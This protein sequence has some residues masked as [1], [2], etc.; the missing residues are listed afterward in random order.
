MYALES[1]G[2]SNET[3]FLVFRKI[4]VN[5][6]LRR[7]CGKFGGFLGGSCIKRCIGNLPHELGPPFANGQCHQ[8]CRKPI[9]NE[10]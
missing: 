7:A 4:C 2:N 5:S 10:P 3:F 1:P 6:L 9:R 8:A